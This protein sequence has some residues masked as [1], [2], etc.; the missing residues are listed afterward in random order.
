MVLDDVSFF[1]M[2]LGKLTKVLEPKVTG[3]SHLN[4]IFQDNLDFFVLFSSV[5]AVAGNRGQAA[6]SAANMYLT[7]LATQRRNKG[8]A[9]SI[10]H[11]GAVMGVGYIN[12]VF[13]E[14]LYQTVA[15][16]GVLLASEREVHLCFAESV[17]ASDPRSGRNP[18]LITA[19]KTYGVSEI[20]P[21]WPKMPRF[22][23]LFQEDSGTNKNKAE[24]AAA[25]SI[26]A[27]VAEAGSP[28]EI[29]QIVQGIVRSLTPTR[30][31][32]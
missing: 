23:H 17:L 30:T 21:R 20:L 4:E 16:A 8:L 10:F 29:H 1:D 5:V 19:M 26:K 24:K 22:Q 2:P 15:K 14:T 9:A 25:V 18:E 3:S 11:I 32:C 28:E 27:R 12:R 13:T 31:V 7:A 6:Y